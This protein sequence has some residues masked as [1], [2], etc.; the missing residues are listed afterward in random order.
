MLF[1]IAQLQAGTIPVSFVFLLWSL[2]GTIAMYGL[3][4]DVQRISDT[5][6]DPV[7]ALLSGINA[8]IVG[9]VALAAVQLARKATTRILARYLPLLIVLGRLVTVIWIAFCSHG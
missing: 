1:A 8:V 9:I 2:P 3:S 7:Y 5:L 4:L 6:P